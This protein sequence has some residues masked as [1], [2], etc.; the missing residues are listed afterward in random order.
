MKKNKTIGIVGYSL[1][2]NSFGAGKLHLDYI[3]N[4]GKP[5]ILMPSDEDVQDIDL[6][7]LP[8]GLDLNPSNYGQA[9]GFFTSNSDVH[10]EYFY[11]VMLPK[12]VEANI[13]IFGVCLGINLCPI[14]Q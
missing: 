2:D 3:S 6:L 12:Y 10:K 8:G 13:P 4:F 14:L 9:P 7:Y 11:R 5:R 1:G